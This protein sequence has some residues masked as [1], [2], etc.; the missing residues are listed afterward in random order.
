[1][2]KYF[3]T[4]VSFKRTIMR[5]A[6]KDGNLPILAQGLAAGDKCAMKAPSELK[7]AAIATL[8]S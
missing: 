1:M 5:A 8:A 4:M 2:S 7:T 6:I 3:G